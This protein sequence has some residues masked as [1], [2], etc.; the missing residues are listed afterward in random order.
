MK[1]K[2]ILGLFEMAIWL[3]RRERQRKRNVRGVRKSAG[4]TRTK[5]E[6]RKNRRRRIDKSG[7]RQK[8]RKG[9]VRMEG[10]EDLTSMTTEDTGIAMITGGIRGAIVGRIATAIALLT[11][12][13]LITTTTVITVDL[14]TRGGPAFRIGKIEERVSRA[15]HPD[16]IISHFHC[17]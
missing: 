9:G 3:L 1:P 14:T 12:G 16:F 7:R 13:P 6:G 2:P 10:N 4:N 8:E 5:N 15:K 11:I 17:S